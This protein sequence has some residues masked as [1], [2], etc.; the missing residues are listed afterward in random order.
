MKEAKKR[1][2]KKIPEFWKVLNR[3]TSVKDASFHDFWKEWV[4]VR[5]PEC[6]DWQIDNI[7]KIVR[8]KSGK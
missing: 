5:W 6:E 7:N 3:K 4:I 2:F 8:K 1:F